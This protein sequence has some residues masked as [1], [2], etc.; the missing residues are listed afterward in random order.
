[1]EKYP[2]ETKSIEELVQEINEILRHPIR[3]LSE[4]EEREEDAEFGYFED[5]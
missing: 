2:F 1:M 5:D 4:E 3:E